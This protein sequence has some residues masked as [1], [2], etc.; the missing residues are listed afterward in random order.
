MHEKRPHLTASFL[1]EGKK[2]DTGHVPT[3]F[4]M[5]LGVTNRPIVDGSGR[6]PPIWSSKIL[7]SFFFFW[8]IVL[9]LQR[10][11]VERA[12]KQNV[13]TL[14]RCSSAFQYILLRS[15]LIFKS[16]GSSA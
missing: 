15:G 7:S 10:E 2:L 8:K 14:S 16:L 11:E 5:V 12:I 6:Y 4:W 13:R 3:G 9:D 1:E